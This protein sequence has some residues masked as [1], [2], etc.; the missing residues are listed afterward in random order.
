ME[1]SP[2][3]HDSPGVSSQDQDAVDHHV[4]L[5]ANGARGD[6][7]QNEEDHFAELWRQFG[8]ANF[9]HLPNRLMLA[10]TVL[11]PFIPA[12][13]MEY[14]WPCVHLCPSSVPVLGQHRVLRHHSALG[15]HG[16]KQ[17]VNDRTW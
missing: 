10:A 11:C 5:A 2:P 1:R 16:K 9:P 8:K 6:D 7:K 17:H 13:H 15:P 4:R 3:G 14:P 12:T